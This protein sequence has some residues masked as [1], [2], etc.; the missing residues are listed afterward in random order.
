MIT[1]EIIRASFCQIKGPPVLQVATVFN[2]AQVALQLFGIGADQKK[3]RLSM[4]A[5]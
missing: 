4:A 2:V 1:D 3:L 5:K